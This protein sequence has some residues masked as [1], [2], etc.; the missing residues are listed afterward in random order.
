MQSLLQALLMLAGLYV[1]IF[2]VVMM[3]SRTFMTN[4]V[5]VAR[6]FLIAG[7]LTVLFLAVMFWSEL[8][9]RYAWPAFFGLV[10]VIFIAG[11]WLLSERSDKQP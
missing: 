10:V 2:I 4:Q 9:G 7:L 5:I 8:R 6:P 3:G 11:R 1:A